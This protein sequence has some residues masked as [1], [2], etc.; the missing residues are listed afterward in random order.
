ML[1][2]RIVVA[3]IA[4][5]LTVPGLSQAAPLSWTSGPS[6]LTRWLDLLPGWQHAPAAR[7]A[8]DTRKNGC[9]MDPNGVPL[10]GPGPGPGLTGSIPAP[11]VKG[12]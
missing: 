4:L 11:A 3:T 9:G 8:R 6:V 12:K 7:S 5:A 10:C 1:R 2:K